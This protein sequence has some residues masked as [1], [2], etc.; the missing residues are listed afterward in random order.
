MDPGHAEPSAPV[1]TE[2]PEAHLSGFAGILQVDG[3]GAY[4]ALARRHQQI[5]LAFCWAHVR[6]KF[7][8][9]HLSRRYAAEQAGIICR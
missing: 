1:P 9:D 5:R 8:H 4:A 3:Y 6:R 7:S 2:R